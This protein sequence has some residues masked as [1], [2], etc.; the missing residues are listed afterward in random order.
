MAGLQSD[1]PFK[2]EIGATVTFDQGDKPWHYRGQGKVILQQG[3]YTACLAYLV[4]MDDGFMLQVVEG[5]IS[6]GG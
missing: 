4:Q 2:Y 3:E 5:D 6:K 1:K